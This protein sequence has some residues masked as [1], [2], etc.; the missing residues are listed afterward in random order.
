MF[1][2]LSLRRQPGIAGQQVLHLCLQGH[3]RLL[4]FSSSL[5]PCLSL[6]R[7]PGIAGQQVLHLCL[8]GHDRLLAFSSSLFPCLS[9]RRQPGIAGQQVLHLCLQGHDRLFALAGHPLPGFALRGQPKQ[10]CHKIVTYLV[11][12]YCGLEIYFLYMTDSHDQSPQDRNN[13]ADFTEL[14]PWCPL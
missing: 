11:K 8:Q 7:Q 5:F 3:D 13:G 2:C 6:R 10:F 4:A 12:E 9:L 1:P 14:K